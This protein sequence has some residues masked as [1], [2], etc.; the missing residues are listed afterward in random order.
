MC[1]LGAVFQFLWGLRLVAV[2]Y[3]EVIITF[4][5]KVIPEIIWGVL[6]VSVLRKVCEYL[7]PQRS[8]ETCSL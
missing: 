8:N 5:E 3:G 1:A 7:A 6:V 4:I 2:Y